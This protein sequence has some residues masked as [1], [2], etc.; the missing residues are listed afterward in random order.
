MIRDATEMICVK[1]IFYLYA[2][3]Y[4]WAAPVVVVVVVAAAVMSDK[5]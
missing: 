2:S 1:T 4:I 5:I 3:I